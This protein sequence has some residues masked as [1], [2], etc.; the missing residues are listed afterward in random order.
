EIKKDGRGKNP[1]VILIYLY[2]TK[3]KLK[4]GSKNFALKAGLI[5][6]VQT[7]TVAKNP[8]T[9]KISVAL[10]QDRPYAVALANGQI[11]LSV[12]KSGMKPESAGIAA[13]APTVVSSTELAETEPPDETGA[14]PPAPVG[15]SS[16]IPVN[17]IGA[18]KSQGPLQV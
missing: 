2:D 4:A 10:R 12:H 7:Q 15:I 11:V 5:R 9:V 8:P 14:P 17:V 13:Q 3:E 16:M 6:Q 1:P 18:V